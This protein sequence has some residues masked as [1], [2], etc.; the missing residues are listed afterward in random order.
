MRPN[1]Y[2]FQLRPAGARGLYEQRKSARSLQRQRARRA[3]RPKAVRR[4]ADSVSC[5][6]WLDGE[7]LSYDRPVSAQCET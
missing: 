3:A 4:M 1:G 5:K 7:F 2:A 6:R